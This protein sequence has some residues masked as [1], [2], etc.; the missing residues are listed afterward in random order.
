MLKRSDQEQSGDTKPEIKRGVLIAR[1]GGGSHHP[2]PFLFGTVGFKEN[3]SK[4]LLIRIPGKGFHSLYRPAEQRD[5]NVSRVGV[6]RFP[7][8]SSSF[9]ILSGK[10]SL[11]IGMGM[12]K[13]FDEGAALIG[14]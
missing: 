2:F 10:I 14:L 6:Q 7:P 12:I 13:G 3:L 8:G 11:M 5:D 9:L 4:I 1:R